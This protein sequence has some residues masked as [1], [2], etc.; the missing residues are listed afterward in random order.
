MLKVVAAFVLLALAFPATTAAK[1]N[2]YV[3]KQPRHE[4]CR[5]HYIAD[6]ER[7]HP[8]KVQCVYQPQPFGGPWDSGHE[9]PVITTGGG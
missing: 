1:P 2:Q 4:H 5:A 3:L 8:L 7:A 6:V 9:P